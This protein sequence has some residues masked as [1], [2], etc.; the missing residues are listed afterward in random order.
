MSFGLREVRHVCLN[1]FKHNIVSTYKTGLYE[2]EP[3]KFGTNEYLENTNLGCINSG[4]YK[5]GNNKSGPH[6]SRISDMCILC[7]Y[8]YGKS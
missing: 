3:Y 1:G 2:S 8:Q 7:M 5:S 6:K 4:P